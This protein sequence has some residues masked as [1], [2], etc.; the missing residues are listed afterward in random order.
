MIG[1]LLRATVKMVLLS[2]VLYGTFFLPLGRY[3]LYG[4]LSRIADTS[5]AQELTGEVSGVL[6]DATSG[7]SDQVGKL[8]SR[9]ED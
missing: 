6:K 2:A 5:E 7:V 4:H 1:F 9:D 8:A 3:T